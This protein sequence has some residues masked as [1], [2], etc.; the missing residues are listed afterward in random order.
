MQRPLRISFDLDDTLVVYGDD[1]PRDPC[2]VPILLQYFFRD[3]L[4]QGSRALLHELHSRAVELWVYTTSRRSERS[5]RLWWRLNR[6][7]RLSGV[8]NQTHHEREMR[9][10]G[11]A[12]PPT[13]LP[14]HWQIDVHV[15]DSEGVRQEQPSH[16]A[17][18]VIVVAPTDGN[19]ASR[20]LEVVDQGLSS[21]SVVRID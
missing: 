6:L 20:V 16:H 3:P 10:L 12:R 9:Q 21:K 7:P 15:D 19:W 4:R 11:L 5:I 1:R 8:I 13:K 2:L 14:G 18:Q 17:V